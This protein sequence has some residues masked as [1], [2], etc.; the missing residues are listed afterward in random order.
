VTVR[1]GVER[2]HERGH[3][4]GRQTGIS[5]Y[6]VE[7]GCCFTWFGVFLSSK[8]RNKWREERERGRE[9]SL[10]ICDLLSIFLNDISCKSLR[11]FDLDA[12][13]LLPRKCA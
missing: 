6:F 7:Y 1:R 11:S 13:Q 4:I 8:D 3:D 2:G 9:N 5:Y 12:N 10:D